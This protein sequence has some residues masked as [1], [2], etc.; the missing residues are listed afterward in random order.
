MANFAAE[1][2]RYLKVAVLEDIA[3]IEAEIRKCQ[4]EV[5]GNDADAEEKHVLYL[6]FDTADLGTKPLVLNRGNGQTLCDLFGNDY[7]A[8]WPGK[9]VRL[10][11]Q[12]R[13]FGSKQTRGIQVEGI[14]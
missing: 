2:A 10:T 12:P 6:K 4:R 8:D 7:E 9:R 3:P 1:T 5:V 13:Q 11:I 14:D